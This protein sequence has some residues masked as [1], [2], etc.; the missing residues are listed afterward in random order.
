MTNERWF[1]LTLFEQLSNIAGDIKRFMDSGDDYSE[2]YFDKIKSLVNMTLADPKNKGR[3]QELLDEISEI[4]R[5]KKG[6]VDRDYII[7]YWDQYTRAIS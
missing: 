7:R 5:Y 4:E 1:S 2:F 3:E 6:E